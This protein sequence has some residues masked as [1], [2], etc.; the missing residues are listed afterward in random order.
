MTKK[1]KKNKKNKKT[2]YKPSTDL[3]RVVFSPLLTAEA[4]GIIFDKKDLQTIKKRVT[5]WFRTADKNYH[6]SLEFINYLAF[7]MGPFEFET[8]GRWM[9][10]LNSRIDN[11]VLSTLLKFNELYREWKKTHEKS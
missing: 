3:I 11:E 7:E 6:Q 1:N 5:E 4:C 8:V 9:D 10:D 2:E